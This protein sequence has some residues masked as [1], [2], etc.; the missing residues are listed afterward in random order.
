MVLSD[1]GDSGAE[2]DELDTE[3][4][5]TPTQM[6]TLSSELTGEMNNL[7]TGLDT[8]PQKKLRSGTHSPDPIDQYNTSPEQQWITRSLDNQFEKAETE[9][10]ELTQAQVEQAFREI[11]EAEDGDAFPL[12]RLYSENEIKL[13]D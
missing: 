12:R 7:G 9:K 1:S 2:T 11:G 3:H 6:K 10:I 13:L 5:E 4:T 8:S